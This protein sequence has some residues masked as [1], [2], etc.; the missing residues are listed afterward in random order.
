MWRIIRS[1]LT[2]LQNIPLVGN[3][4]TAKKPIPASDSVC[5]LAIGFPAP[6]T[7]SWISSPSKLDDIIPLVNMALNM[8]SLSMHDVPV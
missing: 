4:Y 1:G 3:Y 7:D 8:L 2:A 6:D 5:F